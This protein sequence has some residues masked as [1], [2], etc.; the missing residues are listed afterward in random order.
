MLRV[1]KLARKV[2]PAEKIADLEHA[3]RLQKVKAANLMYRYPAK[4][5]RVIAVTGTNG[6]TTTCAYINAIL[7]AAKLKTAVYTT[8]FIEINGQSQTNKTHM[9]IASPWAV[10]RFFAKAKRA[11]VDVVVLEVTSHALDQYRIRGVP[12]E[13]A[14]VTNLSQDHLDYHGTME[15]YAAAKAKLLTDYHPRV[16]ILNADDEWFSYF[17]RR[18]KKSLKT[19]GQGRAT[20][21]IKSVQLSPSGSNFSLVSAKAVMDIKTALLGDFNVYNAAM[22]AVAGQA[23]GV[24]NEY[25]KLGIA[26]LPVVPGRLEPVVA[27]KPFTVLVDYAHTPDALKSVLGTL[28]TLTNGKLRLVFGATGDRDKTK[29]PQMGKIAAKLADYIYL[30]DDETYT[31]SGDIIRAVVK[32]GINKNGGK[33][34]CVEIVDRYQAIKAALKDAQAG[35]VVLLTGM[36]HQDYRNMGGKKIPWDERKIAKKLLSEI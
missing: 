10:Q 33:D 9:T 35:D 19:I 28:K 11:N 23:V 18:V 7:K 2:I 16:T 31:E 36:G 3:Y 29:R 8:A 22:A 20:H 15:N 12:I 14:I 30:T 17:A 26:A 27:D 13:V 21:Q 4:N 25:I 34:K 1:K 6:K 5:M 24:S 32:K